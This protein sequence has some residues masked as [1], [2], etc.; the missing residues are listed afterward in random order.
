M[1]SRHDADQ[2]KFN[3]IMVLSTD[4]T[5]TMSPHVI[6]PWLLLRVVKI[7]QNANKRMKA[8]QQRYNRTTT[9]KFPIPPNHYMWDSM[10]TLVAHQ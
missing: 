6:L 3:A 8:V 1:L 4:T 5:A 7:Q 10:Y 9:R 2:K